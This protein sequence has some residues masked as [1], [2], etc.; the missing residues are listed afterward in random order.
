MASAQGLRQARHQL[1]QR[2]RRGSAHARSRGRPRVTAPAPPRESRVLPTGSGG[3]VGDGSWAIRRPR[4]SSGARRRSSSRPA[5][6]AAASDSTLELGVERRPGHC[7]RRRVAVRREARP[8]RAHA[9]R[10]RLL[11]AFERRGVRR[12]RLVEEV[13]DLGRVRRDRREAPGAREQLRRGVVVE[14]VGER[15]RRA[16]TSTVDLQRRAR[17]VRVGDQRAEAPT[18]GAGY[19]PSGYSAAIADALRRRHAE[20]RR[21]HA[22]VARRRS[23]SGAGTNVPPLTARP[24][25]ATKISSSSWLMPLRIGTRAKRPAASAVPIDSVS[26]LPSTTPGIAAPGNLSTSVVDR[27][28]AQARRGLVRAADLVGER[29]AEGLGVGERLLVQRE[30]AA[31]DDRP[32]EEPAR[33]VRDE[34]GEH[35]HA[36]GRLARD[37]HVV[38]I[39]AEPCD[40]VAA[41]SAAPPAG[42]SAR[43]CRPGRRAARRAPG[44]RGSRARRAGS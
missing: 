17:E 35:R 16:G 37:R 29:L 11:V 43:S 32:L 31:L 12:V 36:A 23:A 13:L 42:P 10:E 33:A 24:S 20:H 9:R 21:D 18:T 7:R 4:T 8:R 30:R 44:A 15:R 3:R 40:V 41:P 22:L 1:A 25:P 6:A 38:R 2:P 28:A 5:A 26:T 34:V 14:L 39:A 19:A 27:H